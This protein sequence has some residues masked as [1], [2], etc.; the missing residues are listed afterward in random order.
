[1]ATGAMNPGSPPWENFLS[2]RHMWSR[3]KKAKKNRGNLQTLPQGSNKSHFQVITPLRHPLVLV[4]Q[5]PFVCR[6]IKKKKEY[7]K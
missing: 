6:F 1:M 3:S 4:S 7:K 2:G 5:L